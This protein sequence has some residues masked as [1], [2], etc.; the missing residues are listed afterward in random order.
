[1]R[2]FLAGLPGGGGPLSL[3]GV[4]VEGKQ[5]A[6][7]LLERVV[8]VEDEPLLMMVLEDVL[9]QLG[10]RLAGSAARLDEAL[11]LVATDAFD[12]AV[13]DVNLGGEASFPVADLLLER[14]IPF[15]FTTGYGAAGIPEK[16]ASVPLLAKPFRQH[17]IERVLAS[18][19]TEA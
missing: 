11:A 18:L 17:D 10:Y 14:G 9:E 15:V 12:A 3:A 5:V 4:G 16:Y 19:A 2:H 13:L 8:L 1:M 6:N 7:G